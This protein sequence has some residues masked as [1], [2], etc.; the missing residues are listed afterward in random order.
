MKRPL[1]ILNHGSCEP[2]KAA[3]HGLA[4]GLAAV[5]GAYN[6]AAWV[7]RRE[8]HLAVNAAMYA[9]ALI[10]ER[11][12]VTHHLDACR[13]ERTCPEGVAPVVDIGTVERAA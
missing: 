8:R 1:P 13:Q 5:M 12:L 11:R 3:V 10:W 2:L 9:L 6:A 4:F 7:Q